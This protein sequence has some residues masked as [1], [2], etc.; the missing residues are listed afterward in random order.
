MV[1]LDASTGLR[2]GEFLA[3]R[4]E[5]VDFEMMVVNVTKSVCRSVIGDT[6]TKT[7][8]GYY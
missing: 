4:W 8:H 2:R 6:K 7:S 3:P 1:L 5:E